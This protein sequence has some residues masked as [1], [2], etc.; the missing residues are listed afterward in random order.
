MTLLTGLA[1]EVRADLFDPLGRRVAV[2]LDASLGAGISMPLVIDVAGLNP[3][4]Y[5]V[6]VVGDG[7]TLSRTV[8]VTR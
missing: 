8:T 1:G 6:R 2:L 3:G 7:G 4:V 5:V